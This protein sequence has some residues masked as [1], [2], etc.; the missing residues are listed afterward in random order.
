LPA[1]A[2]DGGATVFTITFPFAGP[3][4]TSSLPYFD[5]T[6]NVT[7]LGGS[8]QAR[9][10]IRATNRADLLCDGNWSLQLEDGKAFA[11]ISDPQKPIPMHGGVRCVDPPRQMLSFEIPAQDIKPYHHFL[12]ID[13]AGLA[14]RASLVGDLPPAE[15][16]PPGPSLDKDQTIILAQCDVHPV[17]FTGKRL[18]QVSKVLYDKMPL[19]IVSKED[20]NITISVPSEITAQPRDNVGLQLISE[21]N[22]PVIAK[23]TV[24]AKPGCK[25]DKTKE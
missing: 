17:K 25:P 18:D 8:K 24:T 9:F 16:P 5:T 13:G 20:K 14:S 11:L 22:D 6:L 2:L 3:G 1:K 10:L 23:L 4:W 15:P 19:S 21:G 12:L 7:R